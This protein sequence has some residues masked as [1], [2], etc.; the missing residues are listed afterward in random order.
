MTKQT[1][2]HWFEK[3]YDIKC[4]LDEQ[5]V[6]FFKEFLRIVA[7]SKILLLSSWNLPIQDPLIVAWSQLDPER[8]DVRI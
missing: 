2:R 5:A 7:V 8:F 3:R 1:T 6:Y 4:L